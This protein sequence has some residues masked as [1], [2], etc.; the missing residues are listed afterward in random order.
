MFQQSLALHSGTVRALGTLNSGFML[1]GSI[2]KS[3]K[4]YILNNASGKYDFDKEL[5][6]H[7]GFVYS[8]IPQYK[9]LLSFRIS[10]DGFFTGGR[11]N[12]IFQVDLQGNPV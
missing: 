1:T 9:F 2:D 8:I 6:Y 7:D 3:C 10:G 4:L 5:M 12:Q 11:D